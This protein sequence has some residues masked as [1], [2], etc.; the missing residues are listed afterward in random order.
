MVVDSPSNIKKDGTGQAKLLGENILELA[1]LT[2]DLTNIA[3]TAVSQQIEL[4]R[5]MGN[6]NAIVGKLNVRLRLINELIIPEDI[7]EQV[8]NDDTNLL[9]EMD[10]TR[11]FVWRMRVHVRSAINLPFN[12]TT[13][14][15]LP[16]TYVEIGWTMYE[17]NDIN[18]VD[19]V[20]TPCVEKNRFPIWNQEMLYYPP[21]T[22][23]TMDG[24]INI[25]LKDKFQMK[26]IQ[27]VSFPLNALTPF[28]PAH[29][30]LMLKLRDEEQVDDKRSHLYV[31]FTLEE[32]PLYKLSESYANII[33]ENL[34][35][36]PLPKCTDRC[37][38]IVTT[39][40]YKPTEDIYLNVDLRSRT[41]LSQIL[42]FIKNQPYSCFL[43]STLSI[44]I[45][46]V[47]NQYNA[48]CNFVLPRSYLDKDL[49][50]FIMIR[51]AKVI[52]NHS[53]PNV[54][55]GEILHSL[56]MIK[57]SFFSKEHDVVPFKINWFTDSSSYTGMVHSRGVVELSAR[58]VKENPDDYQEK[59][60]DDLDHDKQKKEII[61]KA[62]NEYTVNMSNI[63]EKEKWDILSKELT[64]KQELI[65]RMMKEVD[66]K[67]ESLKLTGAEIIELRK[68]I[69]LLQNENQILRRRL[70]QEEQMQI[71][72][73]VTQEIHK[74]S[75]PELKSKIIKLAQA[76]R[77]ERMR[78]EE[79]E[80]A[81]KQAQNEISNAR[82]MANE[83]ELLQKNHEEDTNKFLSL[84]QE[85]QKIG[86]YRETIKK[87]EEVITKMEGLLKKTMAESQRQKES[88]KELELLRTENLTLQKE[89][90]DYVVNSTP[91]VIGRG[92]AELEKSKK[93]IAR[94]QQLVN[95]LQ[96]DLRNKRPISAEKKELQNEILQLEVKYHK[97]EARV[98]SL[99]DEL[100]QAAR[101]N[102]Q[103]IIGLKSA[104]AEKDALIDNLRSENAI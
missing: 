51:D 82:K 104:L 38:I 86:L 74:M 90:K 87:Q 17:N 96:D 18:Q 84:Q 54:L 24:F 70:G 55:A 32:A 98:K 48:I 43:S 46:K 73:L 41:H 11:K 23:T 85:T 19:A 2:G 64:Q 30:D 36:E 61:D 99:E 40:K 81:L 42:L 27:K 20:R 71:E 97:A 53:M 16:S 101:K 59:D 103:I 91:G 80:K 33:I 22:V 69:K 66:D 4:Y 57:T 29:L 68:Q 45:K 65:H 10:F 77:G 5:K 12:T 67:N 21:S 8:P 39:D 76:Y 79:F 78:N 34:N 93:E 26:P 56:D 44:P 102:S 35:L 28:R 47:R 14:V 95:E 72:A 49:C 3:G 63:P 60:I 9:P 52:S 92:N 1:P 94:L 89:L 31:S 37:N 58:E 83:L 100:A 50:F 7:K 75:L 88:L 25:L 6:T 62:M 13:E 15:K